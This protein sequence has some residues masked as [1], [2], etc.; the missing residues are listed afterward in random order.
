LLSILV[1]KQ[2]KGDNKVNDKNTIIPIFI[3]VSFQSANG[4]EVLPHGGS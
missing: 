3:L 1:A 2:G 4:A